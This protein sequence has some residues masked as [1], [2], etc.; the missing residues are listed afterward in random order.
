[1]GRWIVEYAPGIW[2]RERSEHPGRPSAAYPWVFAGEGPGRP[3]SP[4][5]VEWISD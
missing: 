3:L 2:E 4:M 1:M 5:I